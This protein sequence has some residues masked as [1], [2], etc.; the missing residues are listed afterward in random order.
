M[1]TKHSKYF[2]V[3]LAAVLFSVLLS[4]CA[5]KKPPYYG[6][7]LKKGGDYVEIPE[8]ELFDVPS[9]NELSDVPSSLDSQ[10]L[11]V[12]WKP[13]TRL[14][15]LIFFSVKSQEEIRYTA[16]P[17]E[18]GIIEIRPADPLESGYYCFIQGDP[19]GVFLPGWCFQVE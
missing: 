13:E 12:L 9:V 10:P 18:D 6:G 8:L 15:Y 4:G 1:I 19:L 7:F 17:K 2:I 16:E 14:D 3:L 11:F 5:E